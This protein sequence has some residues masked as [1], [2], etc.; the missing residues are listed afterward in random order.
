MR[1]VRHQIEE[2]REERL[3]AFGLEMKLRRNPEVMGRLKDY[4]HRVEV[5]MREAE[6]IGKDAV[7]KRLVE[8]TPAYIIRLLE[9]EDDRFG[10]GSLNERYARTFYNDPLPNP[11]TPKP[12]NTE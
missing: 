2:G 9:T 4:N 6:A 3:A 12:T 1:R 5:S 7:I 8:K 11:S 10:A